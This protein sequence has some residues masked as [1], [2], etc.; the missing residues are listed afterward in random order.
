MYIPPLIE[1]AIRTIYFQ[2][3]FKE[4]LNKTNRSKQRSKTKIGLRDIEHKLQELGIKRGDT[5]MVHS[6][7]SRIDADADE[8]IDF[9]KNYIGQQG[10]ILMPTHPKLTEENGILIYDVDRSP[11]T[12][13]YLTERFRL[14]E[15]VERSLHPF[16]SI[17]VWGRDKAYFLKDNVNDKEPTLPHGKY[18]PYCRFCLMD[19]KVLCIGVTAIRRA[20]IS[21]VA[22]EVLD[23]DF[24]VKDFFEEHG[25]IIRRNGVFIDKVRVRRANLTKSRLFVAKSQLLREWTENNLFVRDSI[26]GV[27]FELVH[28]RRCM[29]HMLENARKGKTRYPYAPKKV[30]G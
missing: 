29:E 21:H 6:S 28:S 22:E 24:P 16:S 26:K 27:P 1:L 11:S 18:S 4:I 20:T 8:F 30:K 14:S 5:I 2:L 13:G 23:S 7:F 17:A 9:L 19:G 15:G 12:V 25:V 3:G 10:N